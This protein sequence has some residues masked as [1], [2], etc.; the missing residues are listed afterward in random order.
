M[1]QPTSHRDLLRD[2]AERKPEQAFQALVERHI[3]VV[4]ATALCRV[5]DAA[6]AQEVAQNV[7]I[8][9]AR[10]AVWLRSQVSLTRVA[11]KPAARRKSKFLCAAFNL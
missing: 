8:A 4:F 9:L 6:A 2:F 10:K 5:N 1:A 7:L 3:D 11:S